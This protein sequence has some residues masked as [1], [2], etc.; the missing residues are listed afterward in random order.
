MSARWGWALV[1]GVVAGA[2]AV[3]VVAAVDDGPQPAAAQTTTTSAAEGG[4]GGSTATAAAH[5]HGDGRRHGLGH[6]RHRHRPAGRPDAG[7]RRPTT[8]WTRPTRRPAQLLDT[9][10]FSGVKKEDITT[11]NV[12]VYP[13]YSSDGRTITGYQAGNTVSVKIRDIAKAGTIIDAAAGVVGDEIVLQGVS[14]H[15]RRHRRARAR[16]PAR[17]R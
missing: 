16:R 11:T 15:H 12:F 5:R 10:K 7:L 9:L 3:G 6:A 13:Q 17:T 1:G 2:L 4:S 14:L 8:R